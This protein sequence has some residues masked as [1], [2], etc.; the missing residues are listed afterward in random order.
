MMCKPCFQTLLQAHHVQLSTSFP[1]NSVACKLACYR[2]FLKD[3]AADATRMSWDDDTPDGAFPMSSEAMLLDWL[4]TPGNYANWR[5]NDCGITK[6]AIQQEIADI[7]NEEGL[8]HNIN[9]QRTEKTVGHKITHMEAKFRSTLAFMQ[10]TGQGI[11]EEKNLSEDSFKQLVANEWPHFWDLFDI[12]SERSCMMPVL[13]T[14]DIGNKND[15]E[16]SD[17]S[18]SVVV[19][20]YNTYRRNGYRQCTTAAR[21]Q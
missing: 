14:N 21:R 18:S 7:I 20:S 12:M 5:G 3:G 6:I 1:E 19:L 9:R 10:N 16:N 11:K 4:K 13:T 15:E 17:A 2:K 8:K